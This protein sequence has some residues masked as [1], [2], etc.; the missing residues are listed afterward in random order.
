[1]GGIFYFKYGVGIQEDEGLGG[2]FFKQF[3]EIVYPV[4]IGE[5]VCR[6]DIDKI[7]SFLK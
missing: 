5:S 3:P 1:M 6:E 4:L 2:K 7:V